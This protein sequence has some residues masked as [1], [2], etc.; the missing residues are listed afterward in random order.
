VIL[1]AAIAVELAKAS[2]M[3]P[4]SPT[5]RH[6]R[7]PHGW[8]RGAFCIHRH[9]SVDW[10]RP[11]VDWRGAPSSYSGGYQFLASTWRNA[12]GVGHA[13]QWSVREQTYRAYV[14]WRRDGGWGEWGSARACGL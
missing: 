5:A 13:Y 6:F 12:G 11:Y 10:H 8:L 14:V 4:T 2:T 1:I 7:F 9:E 3:Y